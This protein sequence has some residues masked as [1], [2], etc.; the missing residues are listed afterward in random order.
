MWHA[1]ERWRLGRPMRR[2][3]SFSNHST[4]LHRNE[5]VTFMHDPSCQSS[6]LN[7]LACLTI[8]SSSEAQV[9]KVRDLQESVCVSIIDS[10]ALLEMIAA[11]IAPLL[12]PRVCTDR[13][14]IEKGRVVH[15]R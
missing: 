9:H 12:L 1:W 11:E 7:V 10:K 3:R 8:V 2:D 15:E 6:K 5:Q 4:L 13:V 14:H